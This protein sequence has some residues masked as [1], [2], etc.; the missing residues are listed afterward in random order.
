MDECSVEYRIYVRNNTEEGSERTEEEYKSLLAGYLAYLSQ[1]IGDYIWQDQSFALSFVPRKGD[2][3][4]HIFGQT[5]YG[6]NVEDEWFIV[7]LLVQ[8]TSKYPDVV[9]SVQDDDGDFLLMEAAH[10]IPKWLNP[11]TSKNRVFIH[12]GKLHIIPL[13]STPREITMFP[14]GIP[15]L[16]KALE[17]IHGPF[18]TIAGPSVQQAVLRRM[19]GYPDKAKH[20][21]H[22]VN[23]F[24]PPAIKYVLDKKPSLISAAV[25]AF[26]HRDPIDMKAASEAKHFS[27]KQ[28]IMT[29]VC[30]TRCLYAQMMQQNFQPNKKS[31]W[32]LPSSTDPLYK[33]HQ[34]GMKITC[35][36]EILCSKSKV[37][38]EKQSVN[39]PSG[40]EW[41]RYL[42]CLKK[43]GYFKD[44]IEGSKLYMKLLSDAEQHFLESFHPDDVV[45]DDPGS[46]VLSLLQNIEINVDKMR[47]EEKA[48]P[49]EDDDS[50]LNIS[51]EELDEMLSKYRMTASTE[52]A[53]VAN[54]QK[55]EFNLG[56]ITE[57]MKSFVDTVSS[58]EGAEFPGE[59]ENEEIHF[60]AESFMDTMKQLLE[61]KTEERVESSDEED[62][63]SD[64]SVEE[65]DEDV[66]EES[67]EFL[68][69]MEEM[70]RQLGS[71][72]I[73]KSFEKKEK[74]PVKVSSKKTQQE[75]AN[76]TIKIPTNQE[77][78]SSDMTSQ[79][80]SEETVTSEEDQIPVD[81]DL[82]L[83]KNLLESFSSQEGLAGPA[84]N[85]L[86][87]MGVIL[88]VDEER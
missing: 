30:F 65:N 27:P 60:D 63:L 22:Y 42:Q 36:F 20:F 35:G 57:S 52:Q 77:K 5:N 80:T 32:Q 16:S 66:P 81:V 11:E 10:E 29:R 37:N 12:D 17:L 72:M 6:D 44:E 21:Y 28:R 78:S 62:Y 56:K 55:E 59:D 49:R 1:Y 74:Q 2:S 86:N 15:S 25:K 38:I 64:S 54:G 9:V 34:L 46:T 88:P 61:G 19:E 85:I 26:Y 53:P 43:Q 76:P 33:A 71:T 31:L 73:G 8:L 75:E 50:W 87:A 45:T 58:Y 39:K 47:E 24:I 23:C 70:D 48:L 83:V 40:A 67:E 79:M 3:L 7:F 18:N 51:P 13:P 84:S 69:Y 41:E 82:N 68:R 4:A 14:T